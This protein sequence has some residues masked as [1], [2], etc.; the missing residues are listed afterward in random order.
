MKKLLTVLMILFCLSAQAQISESPRVE[1]TLDSALE[2]TGAVRPNQP[3][4]RILRSVVRRGDT[5]PDD[6]VSSAG[7][8]EELSLDY[9]YLSTRFDDDLV[10]GSGDVEEH[11][12]ALTSQLN[13]DTSLSLS[14]SNIA[15]SYTTSSPDF[16]TMAH[17]L[18]FFGHHNLTEHFGIGG[19]VFY[20]DVDIENLNGNTYTYGG[21]VVV[22]TDHDLGFAY[23][24]TATTLSQVDFDSDD[25]TVVVLIADLSKPLNDRLEVG[26]FVGYTD[27][28]HNHEL[29]TAYW[30]VG[31]DLNWMYKDYTFTI[32]YETTLELDDYEDDSV[33]VNVS[34]AF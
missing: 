20:Q 2:E 8:F 15:Y 29:D 27:S 28:L 7:L 3:A 25:D 17:G 1:Y 12:I 26:L 31:T 23:L 10:G 14:Y 11:R 21:G 34:Y 22:T 19:F 24:S 13:E 4:S 18:E 16:E 6:A 33:L 32:G 9:S 5:N 30:S